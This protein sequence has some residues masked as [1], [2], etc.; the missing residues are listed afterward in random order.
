MSI[1]RIA[2]STEPHLHGS[3]RIDLARRSAT[4]EGVV[5]VTVQK[6]RDLPAG[7]K[8]FYFTAKQ[9]PEVKGGLSFKSP[10]AKAQVRA[11]TPGG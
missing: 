2:P 5:T 3:L 4:A 10:T 1:I 9:V 7:E 8:N 11:Y 6:A